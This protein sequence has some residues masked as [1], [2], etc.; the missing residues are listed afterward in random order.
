MNLLACLLLILSALIFMVKYGAG[1]F[2][3]SPWHHVHTQYLKLNSQLQTLLFISAI[4]MS[5]FATLILMGL[6]GLN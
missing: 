1:P 5:S 3:K 2:S 6:I 4:T